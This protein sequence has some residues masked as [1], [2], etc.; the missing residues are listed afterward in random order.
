[1]PLSPVLHLCDPPES[2]SLVLLACG[3]A[4]TLCRSSLLC[5]RSLTDMIFGCGPNLRATEL[6]EMNI[7]L[8]QTASCTD[9]PAARPVSASVLNYSSL[10][11]AKECGILR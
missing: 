3:R 7:K 6:P 1:M 2:G 5:R 10:S 4:E 9:I 11:C 8:K